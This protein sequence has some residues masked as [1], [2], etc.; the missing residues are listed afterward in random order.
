MKYWFSIALTST[1]S[2]NTVCATETEL[3]EVNKTIQEIRDI[4]DDKANGS[5]LKSK[6]PEINID[7][8]KEAASFNAFSLNFKNQKA[9]K[10]LVNQYISNC[11]SK[12]A[13]TYWNELGYPITGYGKDQFTINNSQVFFR[14]VSQQIFSE[15]LG[16]DYEKYSPILKSIGRKSYTINVLVI[17]TLEFEKLIDHPLAVSVLHAGNHQD[18]VDVLPSSE[19]KN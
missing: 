14:Q 4:I 17:D 3:T 6:P 8:V 9:E 11:K 1:I 10:R 15:T 18:L 2:M 12:V 13:I 5:T 19:R 7:I 16:P